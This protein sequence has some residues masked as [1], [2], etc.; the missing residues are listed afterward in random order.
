MA[1]PSSCS[2]I[3]LVIAPAERRR[4]I[5]LLQRDNID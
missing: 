3:I 4:Q 1:V 2:A 5:E